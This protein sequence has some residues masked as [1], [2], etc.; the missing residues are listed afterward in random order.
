MSIDIDISKQL[1]NYRLS[2][3]IKSSARRIGILGESGAGKSMT[4]KCIA[5]IEKPDF[6]KIC[7]DEK[8][9][10]DSDSKINT[11]PQMRCA[12]YM[13]QNY[14]LFPTMTVYENVAAGVRKPSAK[15]LSREAL[16]KLVTESLKRFHIDDL[17]DYYPSKLS[18][19]QKQRVA[20]AR[21]LIGRPEI[22][23]LDEPFS[24]LDATLRDKMQQELA[25]V[26]N[27]Y[28]G[29]VIMVSHNRDEIYRFCDE[30]F[31]INEGK[32]IESGE[33]KEIFLNPHKKET[34][35]LTGCK[36]IAEL[37]RIDEQTASVPDWNLTLR[38][39]REIPEC[40]YIGYRAHDFELLY[41]DNTNDFEETN[42]TKAANII[43]AKLKVTAELPFETNLYF[44]CEYSG[45]QISCFIGRDEYELL[46]QRRFPKALK[47]KEDKILFLEE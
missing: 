28:N 5:G 2:V 19:G 31:V 1:N 40:K 33:K 30:I 7:A 43:R 18:G 24:A 16:N 11:S 37:M 12:G 26:L 46:K 6:G 34:A 44:E 17:K 39:E 25:S 29:T 42:G 35:R 38:T 3:E 45:T 14:A 22:I 9:Y 21:I 13:F 8:V 27:E 23:M 32:I 15:S 47:L 10:F 41:S 4:L 36:N 20:L